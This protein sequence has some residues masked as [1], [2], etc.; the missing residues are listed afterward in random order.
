MKSLRRGAFLFF[1]LIIGILLG[2]LGLQAALLIV[3]P[4]FIF[5][6]MLWDEK[7]YI[8]SQKRKNRQHYAYRKYP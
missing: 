7:R 4:L 2:N 1:V 8:Q 5:W 6:F 3:T